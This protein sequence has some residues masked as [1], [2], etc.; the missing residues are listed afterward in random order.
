MAQMADGGPEFA[1]RLTKALDRHP[2]A[3]KG[4]GRQ[5]WLA[6]TVGKSNEAVRK[7][8]KGESIPER[9]HVRELAAL[10][11]VDPGWLDYGYY[12]R[13]ANQKIIR[14]IKINRLIG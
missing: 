6:K 3:P 14:E 4:R 1:E 13:A 11:D 2:D 9:L 10:L 8:F 7:W 5:T 12:S